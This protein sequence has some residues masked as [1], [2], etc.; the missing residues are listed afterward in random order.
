MSF[1]ALRKMRTD[2]VCP[3]CGGTVVHKTAESYCTKCGLVVDDAPVDDNDIIFDSDGNAVS[4]RTGPPLKSWER[5]HRS[6]I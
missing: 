4:H 2:N 5:I 1:E 3:E 6:L